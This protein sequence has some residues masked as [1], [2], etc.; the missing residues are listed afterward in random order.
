MIKKL[1]KIAN[2]LDSLGFQREADVIDTFIK[3]VLDEKGVDYTYNWNVNWSREGEEYEPSVKTAMDFGE[4]YLRCDECGKPYHRM[5]SGS[6]SER[7]LDV[8]MT[9]SGDISP[10][11]LSIMEHGA[12]HHSFKKRR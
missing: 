5:R 11:E 4:D 9:C 8:C 3:K 10:E 1:V 12:R 7:G 6:K 2:K